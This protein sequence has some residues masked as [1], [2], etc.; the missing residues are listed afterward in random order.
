MAFWLQA[1][2]KNPKNPKQVLFNPYLYYLGVS[3]RVL[4]FVHWEYMG[5][6]DSY[7]VFADRFVVTGRNKY[8]KNLKQV[9]T[10]R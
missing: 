5:S 6:N 4:R 7:F 9:L 2:E 10:D 8:P 1:A 3:E